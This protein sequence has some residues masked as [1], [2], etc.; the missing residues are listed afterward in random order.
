MKLFLQ[1]LAIICACN[2]VV[3]CGPK[4]PTAEEAAK[5]KPVKIQDVGGDQTD[6]FAIPFDTSEF[7]EGQEMDKLRSLGT[8]NEEAKSKKEQQKSAAHSK[9]ATGTKDAAQPKKASPFDSQED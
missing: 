5:Q 6:I 2:F 3:A 7:E 1:V 9:Q 8:R 4:K